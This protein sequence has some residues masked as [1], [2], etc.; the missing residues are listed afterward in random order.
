MCAVIV[1]KKM[2]ASIPSL[3]GHSLSFMVNLAELTLQ[4]HLMTH[5]SCIGMLHKP[6]RIKHYAQHLRSPITNV[7]A[8]RD[9]DLNVDVLSLEALSSSFG[10]DRPIN[11][12]DIQTLNFLINNCDIKITILGLGVIDKICHST[13]HQFF[14]HFKWRG[15]ERETVH[16]NA[17]YHSRHVAYLSPAGS[18]YRGL[19]VS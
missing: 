14:F 17:C 1:I 9:K 16:T 7:T 11:Y 10:V 2:P 6:K 4:C 13:P 18:Y 5:G 3:S 19:L 15:G 12:G 8:Q